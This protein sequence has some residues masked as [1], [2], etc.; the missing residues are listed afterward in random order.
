MSFS[1]KYIVKMISLKKFL[2]GEYILIIYFFCVRDCGIKIRDLFQV[3]A[4]PK[5]SL[6]R[7]VLVCFIFIFLIKMHEID[8]A[9]EV[10]LEP[11]QTY[12][13]EIFSKNS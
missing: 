3:G 5:R 12:M 9:A 13:I 6:N 8:T 1:G 11:F 4:F 10:Y 7:L 2:V